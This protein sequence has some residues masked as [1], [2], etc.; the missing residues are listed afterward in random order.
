MLAYRVTWNPGS[1]ELTLF[2]FMPPQ[3]SST[4]VYDLT[5]SDQLELRGTMD[6]KAIVATLQRAP[7]K[8]HPLTNRGFHWVQELPYNR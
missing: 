3:S 7:E 6:G 8:Q 2:K 5:Q 1:K 4:F